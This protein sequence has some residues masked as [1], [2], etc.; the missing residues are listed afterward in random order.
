VAPPQDWSPS[1]SL[2]GGLLAETVGT[3]WLKAATLASLTTAP[4]SQRQVHR[5]QPPATRKSPGELSRGYLEQVSLL[6]DGL[7]VYKSVL[8]KV[9][10]SYL[11]SLNEALFATESAAWRGGAAASGQALVSSLN[12]Y[13]AGAEKKVSF[14]TSAQEVPMAG[15]SGRVPVSIQNGLLRQAIEVRVNAS[16]D[17]TPNRPSQLTIGRFDNLVI[18]Q[19]G[20][21]VTVKLPVSSAPQGS[22]VIGLSLTSANGTPLTWADSSLTVHS[23][24][25]GRAI[26]FLIAAAIGILILSSVY[27]GVRRSLRDDPDVVDE[28]ADLPGSV[29]T[30]SSARHPT[31][32]PD[33]LAD[34]WRWADDA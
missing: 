11:Q 21:T 1:Q 9:A 20:Q 17:N 4:D 2:A 8:F 14:I 26:L 7:G 27:R 15:S 6:S 3:P 30:G 13:L 25:Y 33:D 24:R 12:E 19:P 5:Q 22:T 31:E 10:P 28:E 23:T 16:A 29:V 32:A 18:I 34:A